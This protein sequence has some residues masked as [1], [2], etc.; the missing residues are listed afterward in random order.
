MKK[1]F[2]FLLFLTIAMSAAAQDY[3]HPTEADEVVIEKPQEYLKNY[4]ERRSRYGVIASVNFEQYA[5][6][7]YFS[8]SQNKFFDEFTKNS[9]IGLV[10]GDLGLK[11]NFDLGSASVLLGVASGQ[12]ESDAQNIYSIS[13]RIVRLSAN[14]SMDTLMSEPWIVP[15]GQVGVH[16]L[17]WTEKSYDQTNALINQS[18]TT[19]LTFNYKVGLLFQLNWIESYIDPETQ[20]NGLRSSGLE[21]TFIDVFY[22]HYGNT[23]EPVEATDSSANNT[24]VGTTNA[25]LESSNFGIGLKL[26]F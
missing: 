2:S 26:E 12:Y 23:S 3:S 9:K 25:D 11:V 16:Q 18:L 7:D 10:S 17:Y 21:N 14:F 4:R 6:N 15:Y 19:P 20:V 24:V 13:A 5:P 8:I 22:Q 1:T